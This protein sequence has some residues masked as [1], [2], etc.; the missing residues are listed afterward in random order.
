M[1][2]KKLINC[3]TFQRFRNNWN[4][5]T[6]D[7]FTRSNFTPHLGLLR[8]NSRNSCLSGILILCTFF[9]GTK[10]ICFWFMTSSLVE[11][12]ILAFFRDSS[13]NLASQNDYMAISILVAWFQSK[14]MTHHILLLHLLR[15]KYIIGDSA[16]TLR[17][18]KKLCEQPKNYIPSQCQIY[19]VE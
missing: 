17:K 13:K 9:E 3:C 5:K 4:K 11:N 16:I 8:I 1:E 10:G 15:R 12:V 18:K 2:R 6:I 19:R 14:L 7:N